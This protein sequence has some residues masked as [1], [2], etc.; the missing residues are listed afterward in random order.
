VFVA[1][2]SSIHDATRSAW[3][4]KPHGRVHAIERGDRT[5]LLTQPAAVSDGVVVDVLGITSEPRVAVV[6]LIL[7]KFLIHH[8]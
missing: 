2:S 8:S 4:S 7:V 5:E 3:P 1:C 6:W